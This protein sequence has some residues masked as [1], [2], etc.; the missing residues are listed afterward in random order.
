M[1]SPAACRVCTASALVPVL[2]LGAQPPANALNEGR[3]YPLTLWHCEECGLLQIGET[4]PREDLFSHYVWVTGTSSTARAFAQ[5]FC[6]MAMEKFTLPA[7]ARVVEIASN[8]GTFLQP[9][10]D[11]GCKCLGIDPAEN[12]AATARKGGLEIW[13][14]F[15][16]EATARDL[17]EHHERVDFVFARNVIAH[18]SDLRGFAAGLALLLRG[19]G[20]GAVEFHWAEHILRGLQ[21][22]SIYHEHLCYFSLRSVTRLLEHHGLQVISVEESPIS[23]GALIVY[24]SA[25]GQP[26]TSVARTHEIESASRLG[27]SATWRA[28]GERCRQHAA[29]CRRLI[30]DSALQPIVG[31]GSSARSNTFLNFLGLNTSDLTA[32]IDNNSAKQGRHAPGSGIPIVSEV[33][34]L[35]MRPR[36]IFCLAWNFH[37]ELLARCQA[38][39]FRG[40]WITAFPGEPHIRT[41]P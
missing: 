26:D 21:Y 24:F 31:Y 25:S 23:G 40:N 36:S 3:R 16:D 15:W 30:S 35:A 10:A 28:F 29:A 12:I 37:E 18:A 7:G 38:A 8:D 20:V 19:G 33:E 1:T 6:D 34:G 14:R 4:L 41:L 27:D 2:D 17:V 32:I 13:T 9:F 39:G 5:R 11:K 22:D